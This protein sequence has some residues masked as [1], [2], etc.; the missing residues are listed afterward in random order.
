MNIYEI[1]VSSKYR[2]IVDYIKSGLQDLLAHYQNGNEGDIYVVNHF[3]AVIGGFGETEI[4]IFINIPNKPGNNFSFNKNG[5]RCFMNNLVIGIKMLYDNSILDADD[6]FLYSTEGLL[7]YI[8]ELE[9]ECSNLKDFSKYC[10]QE[11][12]D[13]L[14][15]Y[16][17]S[18][19]SCSKSFSNNHILFNT[20]LN[21]EKVFFSACYRS[22]F[23]KSIYCLGKKV[24]NLGLI[25][26][27][28][29]E[30]ANIMSEIGILTKQRIDEITKKGLKKPQKI[31]ENQGNV[32]TVLKGKAGSGKTLML[33]RVFFRIVESG[34]HCRFLT[35]NNLLIY[36]LKYCLCRMPVFRNTN[37]YIHTLHYFFYHLSKKMGIH[38]LF[39]EKR[40]KELM[41]ICEQRVDIADKYIQL[42]HEEKHQWPNKNEFWTKFQH[43]IDNGDKNEITKYLEFWD[44]NRSNYQ[45]LNNIR[46]EYIQEREKILEDELGNE[47]FLADY[48]KVLETMYLMLDNPREFYEKYNIKNRRELLNRMSKIDK[49]PKDVFDEECEFEEFDEV[50]QKAIMRN[51]WWSKSVL[52]DEAQDCNIYEK[53]ILMKTFGFENIVVSSGGEDQLI[54]TSNITDWTTALGVRPIILARR[55]TSGFLL[56][57][58]PNGSL[59]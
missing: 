49:V 16:W 9:T 55:I 52:I 3:P 4:L 12:W 50:L 33:T 42:F 39:T 51:K 21:I 2:H 24:D 35:Y 10:K 19:S 17:V 37:A 54:R 8:E 14:Y 29:I 45:S 56:S 48:N 53:L 22:K 5:G 31:L 40:L 36:D 18:S 38:F 57:I 28:Y 34:H 7:N 58:F 30:Q 26:K 47:L 44:K 46:E 59:R 41:N 15:F 32:L 1:N 43:K 13:C 11:L 27:D 20:T 23:D 6:T 25:V